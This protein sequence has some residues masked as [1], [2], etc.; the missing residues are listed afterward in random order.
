[1]RMRKLGKGQSVL[2]C[3]SKEVERKILSC[4]GKA[5]GDPIEVAD[6]LQWSISE[7]CI[8]TKKSVPLWA[9]QGL[10]HQR[11]LVATSQ[12]SK[13]DGQSDPVDAAKSLLETEAQSLEVRYGIG[14]QGTEEQI[15]LQGIYEGSLLGRE[16]QIQAIREKCQEFEL[17]SFN[18]ATLREEQERELSPENEQERQVERPPALKPYSHSVHKDVKHF[19][20]NG[21]LDR[22][23]DAFQPA[24]ELFKR[25]S[26]V[27]FFEK[28]KWPSHLLVTT[29]FSR[30]VQ[31]SS[32]Q[33]LDSYLRPVN[34]I[35]TRKGGNMVDCLI[36]SP[37]EA[38]ELLPFIRQGSAVTLHIYSPQVSMSARLLEDLT[39]CA[40][41]AMPKNW[42]RPPFVMQLN[43]FAGQPYLSSYDEYLSLCRF[44]GLSS[45]PPSGEVKVAS[46]GFV[47]LTD[48]KKIDAQM[49]HE[50]PFTVSPVGFLR[51]L[52][53]LRRKGQSFERSHLGKI[54]S[55]DLLT[56]DNFR[57]SYGQI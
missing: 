39:F 46:D 11:R 35:A 32:D 52:M 8:N 47:R 21:V 50:C 20:H 18:N 53:A 34:W 42:T 10:R 4:N 16:A 1:M 45:R 43:L 23:S 56:E 5:S 36:L 6:V 17:K 2:F 57:A 29:D 40:I 28:G 30:T 25:T 41:P 27:E 24:F 14:G 44:L 37:Y 22:H 38:H 7:T 9:I 12:S 13:G 3:C 26:A 15:L 48:R 31:T 51:M 54:L 33:F 19:I 55:G 49:V